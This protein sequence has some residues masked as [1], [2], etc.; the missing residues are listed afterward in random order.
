MFRTTIIERD[1]FTPSS[2]LNGSPEG[3]SNL[4]APV[5]RRPTRLERLGG[6]QETRRFA[7]FVTGPFE[8]QLLGG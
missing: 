3:K 1:K 8:V 4:G 7:L 6:G 5:H 2:P